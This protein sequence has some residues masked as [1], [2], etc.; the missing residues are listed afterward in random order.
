M[1]LGFGSAIRAKI[2]EAAPEVQKLAAET[3]KE[4]FLGFEGKKSSPAGQNLK[5]TYDYHLDAIAASLADVPGGLDVLYEIAKEKHP[6][7]ILPFKELY[8]AADSTKFGPKLKK[9]ITPILMDE[10]I[11][12]FVGKNRKRLLPLRASESQNGYPGGKGEPLDE[13]AS[14]YQRAG[15]EGYEWKMF[16]DLRNAEWSYHSFDP[17]AAEQVPFDQLVSRY[18]EVT[19]P[20]GMEEWSATDFNAG[21]AGWK[22]GKS[23]FGTYDGKIPIGPITKCNPTCV[24]PGCYGATP[25]NTHW[26]KEVLLMSGTFKIPPLKEGHRYRLR[27]NSGDHVGAGGGHKIF[28]NGKELVEAKQGGGRGS[29]GRPKGAYITKEFLDDFKS[30]EV[31]IAVKTFIRYNAKYST[32]PSS[33]VP[34]GKFS[35]H[36]DEQKLPPM[37]DEL[38][39]KSAKVVAMTSSDWQSKLDKE[40]ASQNPDDNLFR[41]DGKVISN[42][43]ILGSWQTVSLVTALEDFNPEKPRDAN[44]ARIKQVT[45]KSDGHTDE[46]IKVWSGDTLM[47]LE[48]Y[49]ALKMKIVTIDGGEYLLVEE[50]EFSTRH[51]PDWKPKWIVLKKKS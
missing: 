31:T 36:L 23:P 41:W 34:Q 19:V 15:H 35:L 49:Q 7:E 48:K 29:G 18:R 11:P 9:A 22:K 30:G 51:K 17:I 1:T 32:K 38:V 26:E 25:I 39:T 20:K 37:G 14:L 21:K 13:L 6:D 2:K 4:T 10:L 46:P 12:E 42:E 45:F 33:K 40:D 24:G 5:P 8:L 27:E 16:L 50:G 47:D 28:V 43:K 3:L 44:R